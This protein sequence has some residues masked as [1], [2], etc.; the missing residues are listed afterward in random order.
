MRPGSQEDWEFTLTVREA[1]P[2]D[3]P[4]LT[5]LFDYNDVSA[6]IAEN[7]RRMETGEYSIFLLLDD[8]ALI[9]ELHVTWR[10]DDPRFAVDGRRAY[11]SAFRVRE[12]K[13]GYGFGNFLLDNVMRIIIQGGY[14]EITIGVEDDNSRARHMYGKRGFTELVARCSESYQGDAY[15]YDLLLRRNAEGCS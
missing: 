6:M 9:G 13:Q 15:A 14:R 4:R 8:D 10:S 12:D 1:C 11:L 2:A 5:E 3:L 7:T